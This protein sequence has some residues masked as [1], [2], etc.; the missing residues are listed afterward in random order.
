MIALGYIVPT[1]IAFFFAGPFA[2]LV[3]LVVGFFIHMIILQ[4]RIS[5]NLEKLIEKLDADENLNT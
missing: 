2:P 4:T 1:I 5:Q 3:G